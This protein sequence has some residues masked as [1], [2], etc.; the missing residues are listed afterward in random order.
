[1]QSWST[2][3]RSVIGTFTAIAR[4][5]FAIAAAR[6]SLCPPRDSRAVVECGGRQVE[7]KEQGDLKG[8]GRKYFLRCLR[9]EFTAFLRH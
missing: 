7:E 1:L 6:R 3:F 9:R 8:E 5:S 4:H 2:V